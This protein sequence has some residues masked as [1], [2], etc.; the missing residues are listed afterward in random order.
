[1]DTALAG[2]RGCGEECRRPG[3]VSCDHAA[4]L[5]S[6]AAV[7]PVSHTTCSVVTSL[8]HHPGHQGRGWGPPYGPS[9]RQDTRVVSVACPCLQPIIINYPLLGTAL[10]L[11]HWPLHWL[12]C[13][14]PLS[15]VRHQTY[16]FSG[17]M[18]F[19]TVYSQPQ[20]RHQHR[21][22]PPNSSNGHN[23]R[24]ARDCSSS[25]VRRGQVHLSA[26]EEVNCLHLQELRFIHG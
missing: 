1:M 17:N 3:L 10:S 22:Q 8:Q 2:L 18:W 25:S 24:E 19:V 13:P 16:F 12:G 23:L 5:C 9:T 11:P 7:S 15:L 14:C 4:M 21:H 26:R 6:A 20:H